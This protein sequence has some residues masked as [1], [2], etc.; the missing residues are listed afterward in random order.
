MIHYL[1]Q[2][3]TGGR[4]SHSKLLRLLGMLS[5][6]KDLFYLN[7]YVSEWQT[8]KSKDYPKFAA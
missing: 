7:D 6:F 1:F 2:I 5:L 3:P 4:G 8:A